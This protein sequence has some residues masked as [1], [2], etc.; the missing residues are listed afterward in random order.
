[1]HRSFRLDI[2]DGVKDKTAVFCEDRT[3]LQHLFTHLLRCAERQN[4][5]GVNS[6]AVMN[7]SEISRV[8]FSGMKMSI[9]LPVWIGLSK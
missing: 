7:N 8:P 6:A 3:T 9:T 5:L 2:M 1:M 4:V